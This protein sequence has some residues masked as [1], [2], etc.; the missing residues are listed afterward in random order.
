MQDYSITSLAVNDV[1]G[2]NNALQPTT[3]KR[4]T[5][6]VGKRGPFYLDFA[7]ADYTHDAVIQGVM[8]Q[9][10]TLKKIDAGLEVS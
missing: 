5:F 1:A 4:V 9:V 7:Q 10:N 6:Y 2:V 3:T 8:G